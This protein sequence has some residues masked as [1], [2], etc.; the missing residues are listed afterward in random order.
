MA[1][2]NNQRVY[3]QKGKEPRA[4]LARLGILHN[5][6]YAFFFQFLMG[7]GGLHLHRIVHGKP[8]KGWKKKL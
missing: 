1:M 7:E 4:R 5:F 6:F 3:V 8:M 2:L